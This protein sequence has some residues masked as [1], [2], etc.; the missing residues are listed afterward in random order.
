MLGSEVDVDDVA[1]QKHWVECRGI[2]GATAGIILET[3]D[4]DTQFVVVIVVVRLG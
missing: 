4:M 3:T 2:D 1:F